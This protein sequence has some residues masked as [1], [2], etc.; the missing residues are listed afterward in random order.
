VVQSCKVASL[1]SGSPRINSCFRNF[2]SSS[3]PDRWGRSNVHLVSKVLH[4][5]CFNFP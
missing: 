5:L 3:M 4:I 1:R 2:A